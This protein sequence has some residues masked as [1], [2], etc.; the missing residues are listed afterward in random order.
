MT[1]IETRSTAPR[2]FEKIMQVATPGTPPMNYGTLRAWPDRLELDGKQTTT[3]ITD[4]RG[5]SFE[6]DCVRVTHGAG[7]AVSTTYLANSV[8]GLPKTQ[9]EKRRQFYE[10]IREI[11]GGA[12]LSSAEGER[13]AAFDDAVREAKLAGARKSI[14]YGSLLA[15][16]GV[17]LT[18]IT[19]AAA[20]GGGTYILAWGPVLGG[21]A[22]VITGLVNQAKY[23]GPSP[24]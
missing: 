18:V 13:V 1:E 23:R 6:E 12:D 8:V 4:V 2:T 19:Y 22:M 21:I 15:I 10:A 9:R 11:C 16:A 14:L 20:T 5:V 24:T 3:T 17:V 7:D